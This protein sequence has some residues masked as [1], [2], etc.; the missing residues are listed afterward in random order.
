[1]K[2]K[3]LK[4]LACIS[5]SCFCLCGVLTPAPKVHAQGLTKEYSKTHALAGTSGEIGSYTVYITLNQTYIPHTSNETGSVRLYTDRSVLMQYTCSGNITPDTFIPG[6]MCYTDA[7]KKT[8]QN[9]SWSSNVSAIIPARKYITHVEN[10]THVY[11]PA[12]NSYYFFA[13]LVSGNYDAIYPT[14]TDSCMLK[15]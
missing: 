12:S 10:S 11:Y 6:R 13:Q 9:F 14:F 4:K 2:K 1:M 15:L 8:V 7:D 5:L 3:F